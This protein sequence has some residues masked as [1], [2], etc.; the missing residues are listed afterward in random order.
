M[1]SRL[2]LEIFDLGDG[3]HDAEEARVSVSLLEEARLSAYETGYS[4]GWEDAAAA[5]GTEQNRI[6]AEVSRSLQAC[7]FTYLEARGHVL[8]TL[9]PLLRDMV[10]KVLPET[11]KESLG[12]MILDFLRPMA[13]HMAN[14]PVS[15]TLHPASRPMVETILTTESSLPFAFFEQHDLNEGEVFLRFADQEHHIDLNGVVAAIAEAVGNFFH[16]EQQERAHG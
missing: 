4:A 11:A 10:A 7:S 16:I 8:R 1:P 14:A 3:R 15:V 6:Q 13:A 5:Q 12:P 9:E 2:K